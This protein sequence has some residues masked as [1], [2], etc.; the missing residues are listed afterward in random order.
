MKVK[1][2]NLIDFLGKAT[3]GGVIIDALLDFGHGGLRIVAFDESHT[4]GVNA[5]LYKDGNFQDYAE[6]QVPIKDTA[7][8]IRLLKMIDGEA[9]LLIKDGAFHIIGDN[10]EGAI[11]IA[12]IENLK[13][14]IPTE[15]WPRLGYERGFEIDGSILA[16]MKK[17]AGNLG[18]K[19]ITAAVKDGLFTIQIGKGTSDIGITKARVEYGDV[20]AVYSQTML[21]FAQ[22]IKGKVRIAFKGDSP[23]VITSEDE[24]SI[25]EWMIAPVLPE[26]R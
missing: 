22:A 13:C 16:N 26:K 7:K 12:K 23:M 21:D 1:T 11:G 2:E 24:N 19:D 8:L 15:K 25:V 6:M 10:F 17:T 9:E 3:V 5:L 20:A 18:C 14:P 4:G